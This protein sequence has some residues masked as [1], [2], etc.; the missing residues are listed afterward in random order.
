MIGGF[1][2]LG[3][4]LA[5]IILAFFER[6]GDGNVRPLLIIG[7]VML[8]IFSFSTSYLTLAALNEFYNIVNNIQSAAFKINYWPIIS[9]AIILILW[10]LLLIVQSIL[11]IEYYTD[12][13]SFNNA[14]KTVV[15]SCLSWV[16]NMA[17]YTMLGYLLEKMSSNR[18]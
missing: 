13:Y 18:N 4:S 9:Q 1:A 11:E 16:I 12:L 2:F 10:T 7:F 5:V 14:C 17:A 15:I 8:I 6:N 3:L